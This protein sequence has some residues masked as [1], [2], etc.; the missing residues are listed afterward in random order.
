[1]VNKLCKKR[2]FQTPLLPGPPGAPGT[3]PARAPDED[4]AKAGIYTKPMNSTARSSTWPFGAPRADRSHFDALTEAEDEVS[5]KVLT[6]SGSERA[7]TPGEPAAARPVPFRL[8]F[9]TCKI[10]S[11]Y[12]KLFL[13]KVRQEEQLAAR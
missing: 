6:A 8:L 2:P 1:M 10:H 7:Q 12:I 9:K 3:R 11:L 13:K 4:R 5:V